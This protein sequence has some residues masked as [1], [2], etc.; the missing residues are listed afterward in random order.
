MTEH[1]FSADRPIT[2]AEEDLLGRVN[3]SNNLANA[4]SS[5]SGKDSLVVALHGRWGSGKSSIKNMTLEKLRS[6]PSAIDVVE[7]NPW[8]WAAQDKITSSFFTEI[9][10]TIGRKDR[11]GKTKALSLTLLKYSQYLTTGEVVFSSFLTGIPV[12]LAALASVGFLT[13]QWLSSLWLEDLSAWVLAT[14]GVL[15]GLAKWGGVRLKKIGRS[16]LEISKLDQQGLKDIRKELANLLK[17]RKEPLIVVMDD[18]DRLTV[19]QL[20]MIF[21]LVKAN[22]DFPNVVFLLIFQRDIV[23]DKL[24]TQ[25]QTGRDFLEKIIQVPFDIPVIEESRVHSFLFNQLDSMIAADKKALELF[26]NQYWGNIFQTTLRY[27]L[28]DLRSVNRYISTLSFH[29][30]LMSG[31]RA[32]EV[33]PVDLMALECMRVFEPD[34][35]KKISSSKSTLAKSSHQT[36]SD[37]REVILAIIDAAPEMN[38]E[39]VKGF[40]QVVF[41]ATKYAI[42]NRGF[43]SSGSDSFK[44]LRVCSPHHFDKYFLLNTP[45]GRLS[46]S[47]L[48]ELIELTCNYDVFLERLRTLNS[49]GLIQQ[50]LSQ[51]ELR[52]EDIPLDNGPIYVRAMIDMGDVVDSRRIGFTDFDSNT[53]IMRLV[54]W[55]LFRIPNKDKRAELLIE[56]FRRSD[57]LS[58]VET[59]LVTDEQRLEKEESQEE[60]LLP[61]EA[62]KTLKTEFIDRLVAKSE[63]PEKILNSEH[64][65]SWLYHWSEWGEHIQPKKWLETQ[66][67]CNVISVLK[68]FVSQSASYGMEDRV[69][70]IR[71]V[72][73]LDDLEYFLSIEWVSEI[74]DDLNQ[75]NMEE[76]E[77]QI[78]KLYSQALDARNRG[79]RP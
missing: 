38:R 73:R 40:F 56:S 63:E 58:I 47:E 20:R 12:F 37:D 14:L 15:V 41:P 26:D 71:N 49:L 53:R 21:Q 57:G 10:T 17:S 42:E 28:R 43:K 36:N 66:A 59:L 50:V 6:S 75:H 11:S 24:T 52:S 3:F 39:Y 30:S 4:L 79:V 55:F 7:F 29:F 35:Y 48:T 45:D 54:S 27:Y 16:L 23:E 70:R 72:M 5:W 18:I 51:L 22:A 34:V 61:E 44:N 69:S 68:I 13:S 8:E 62:T 1:T 78:L 46:N 77:L 74:V 76:S 19:S 67:K 32:N 65:V 31:E 64:A 33:N 25:S 9:S 2:K 60:L